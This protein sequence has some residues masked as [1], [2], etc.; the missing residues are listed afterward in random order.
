MKIYNKLTI[1]F[2]V[3]AISTISFAEDKIFESAKSSLDMDAEIIRVLYDNNQVETFCP[4]QSVGCYIS[5]DGGIILLS[6]SIPSDHKDVVLFG[7][8]SDYIQHNNTGLIDDSLTCNLKVKHL[9]DANKPKLSKL[10][11]SQCDAIYR[12]KVIVMN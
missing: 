4:K 2:A 9:D 6:D 7:L 8:Y 10:Y 1:F 11:S 5:K 12:N 3:L